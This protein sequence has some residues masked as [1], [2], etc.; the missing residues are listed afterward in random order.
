[1]ADDTK[2]A[3]ADTALEPDALHTAARALY[4]TTPDITLQQI[5]ERLGVKISDVRAWRDADKV[6]GNPWKLAHVW[7]KPGVTAKV[8]DVSDRVK[9]ELAAVK[10]EADAEAR[11][12]AEVKVDEVETTKSALRDRHRREW[13]GPRSLAYQSMRLAQ[14]GAV[15]AAFDLAKLAKISAET[16][17]IIQ[18]GELRALGLGD[19][20]PTV[21]IERE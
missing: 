12:V 10:Q 18:Q 11:E 5:A 19:E 15:A 4:E 13:I 9:A 14:S 1:M 6:A 17:A 21:V 8:N 2:P 20:K 3:A 16:I 7:E